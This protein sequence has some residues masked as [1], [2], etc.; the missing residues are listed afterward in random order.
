LQHPDV[1]RQLRRDAAAVA[2]GLLDIGAYYDTA[3]RMVRQLEVLCL[4][5][6]GTVF[7]FYRQGLDPRAEGHVRTF[8]ALCCDM[9]AT[10]DEL[11]RWRRRQH[12]LRCVKGPDA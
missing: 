10:F 6:A 11:D 5:G 2:G 12:H 8:R 9:L 1:Y 3:Q 7:V 4:V